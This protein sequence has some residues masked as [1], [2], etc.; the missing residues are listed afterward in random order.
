MSFV[1]KA[2]TV[3]VGTVML[4][5]IAVFIG[6]LDPQLTAE[7]GNTDAHPNG[8]L[9]LTLIALFVVGFAMAVLLSI[10]VDQPRPPDS[11]FQQRQFG[12]DFRQ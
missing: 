4:L 9:T 12:G 8:L 2:E 10:F 5:I 11:S 7:L 3:M 1:Q 6:A